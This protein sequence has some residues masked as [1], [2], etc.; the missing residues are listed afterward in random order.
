MTL[1]RTKRKLAAAVLVL[2]LS[3][4]AMAQDV[5]ALQFFGPPEVSS[6]GGGAM[7]NEGWFASLDG[8]YWSV[9]RPSPVQIGLP[10]VDI[11]GF[12]AAF[13]DVDTAFLAA[14]FVSGQR[15]EVGNVQDHRGWLFSTYRLD[16]Q[17][18]AEQFENIGFE[19]NGEGNW[20]NR[21]YVENRVT[22]WSIELMRMHRS[23]QLHNGGFIEF[24][25]GVRYMEMNE[26]F[27]AATSRQLFFLP[28][29]QAWVNGYWVTQVENHIVGPQLGLRYFHKIERFMV[30]VE[31]RAMPGVNFQNVRSDV[32]IGQEGITWDTRSF[33]DARYWDAFSVVLELRTELR[34]QL[35]RNVT[36]RAGWN[37]VWMD[38]TIR[39]SHQVDYSIPPTIVTPR[40]RMEGTFL[41]G[42]SIGLD[43]NR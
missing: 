42:V 25:Y 3:A 17:Q 8:L 32:N 33:T 34:F 20:F 24:M 19:F 13:S 30:N 5:E 10:I 23:R 18:Q 9:S 15:F 1:Y 2:L 27:S 38:N 28:D 31:G 16:T 7:P 4:P 6:Y 11:G 21:F 40:E 14:P 22:N 12:P 29:N 41:H 37:G 35:T 36:F 26:D 39:A 43:L